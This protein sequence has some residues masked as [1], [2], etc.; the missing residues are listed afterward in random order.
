[1]MTDVTVSTNN[2]SSRLFSAGTRPPCEKNRQRWREYGFWPLEKFTCT[3]RTWT[4][5]SS[6]GHSTQPPM[7]CWGF[8]RCT[9]W[10]RD[11]RQGFCPPSRSTIGAGRGS[12]K[13]VPVLVG[14]GTK[15]APPGD[16]F[17]Q[18]L[19][20]MGSIRGR[21]VEHVGDHVVLS[22]KGVVLVSSPGTELSYPC[23]SSH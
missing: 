14:D 7:F 12:H 20:E 8:L 15:I 16:L 5:R 2:A 9:L 22:S 3:R 23:P 21:L 4:R 19:G 17:Y 18:P 13:F 6:A 10:R 1:M 11:C